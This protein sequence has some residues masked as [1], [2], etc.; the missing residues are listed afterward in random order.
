VFE[1]AAR[2]HS[3]NSLDRL[4]VDRGRNGVVQGRSAYHALWWTVGGLPGYESERLF[5]AF[6]VN[7]LRAG[8]PT[9]RTLPGFVFERAGPQQRLPPRGVGDSPRSGIAK[10]WLAM[11]S[12]LAAAAAQPPPRARP[13]RETERAQIS[14][15]RRGA[16]GRGQCL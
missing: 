8:L 11:R 6:S 9:V 14:R 5:R 7:A 3:K 16:A 15:R 13:L 1:T 10:P 4:R 2:R 12:A